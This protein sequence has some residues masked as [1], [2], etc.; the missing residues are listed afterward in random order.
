M[1]TTYK[2]IDNANSMIKRI[3]DWSKEHDR[4]YQISLS[5]LSEGKLPSATSRS[6]RAILY[7]YSVETFWLASN[8][9]MEVEQAY[10]PI[11]DTVA[12]ITLFESKAGIEHKIQ[13]K[14][15]V[16]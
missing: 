13:L 1:N 8:H 14:R 15:G 12:S 9:L 5:N 6:L 4:S 11:P 10:G 16:A 7:G 3:I 2:L